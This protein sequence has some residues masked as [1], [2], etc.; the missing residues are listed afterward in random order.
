MEH[1]TEAGGSDRYRGFVTQG[2][3]AERLAQDSGPVL[4][5]L[6]PECQTQSK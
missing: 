1:R 5:L 3:L 4:S 6:A 2:Q